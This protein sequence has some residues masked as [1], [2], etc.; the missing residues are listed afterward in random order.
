A[1]HSDHWKARGFRSAAAW[2]AAEANM[3]V[4]PAIAA[5][6]TL[7]LL[8]QLPATASAFR[9]GHLS[10]AQVSEIADVAAEWPAAEQ[11]LLDSAEVMSLAELREECRRVKAALVTDEDERYRRLRK[12]RYL[13]SWTDRDGAV[14]LS[15]RLT[16]D[17]GARLL[18]EVDARCG[19]MERDARAGGWYEGHDA[20]R[21]D[22]LVDLART[23]GGDDRAAGSEAMV[24]VWVDYDA[25][26]RGEILEGERC[27]IPG[28]GPV[29]VSV[30][31]RMAN[32]SILKVIVTKG[33]EITAVAHAGRNIKAHQR[34]ALLAR[35]PKCI[36]PGCEI[37]RGLQFDHLG[38]YV[39][40]RYTSVESLARL[41][42]WHHYQKS[43]C[44]YTYRGGPG[45]WEWI[46][47]E[48]PT[49]PP[50]TGRGS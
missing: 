26:V 47:P 21:A 3:P 9:E 13:R 36:V 29:P 50:L 25:L 33:V 10:L 14:R 48:I 35:D 28:I 42:P 15:G 32:D 43:H 2:M 6:E 37:R 20:H 23:A 45:T 31:K 38:P 46:P 22:A 40:T 12:G 11:Q 39:E 17:E 24:H 1:V 19:E 41:C 4:G 44:G 8:D 18:A 34:T 16:P 49:D 30:A 27:E 7:R 5:M